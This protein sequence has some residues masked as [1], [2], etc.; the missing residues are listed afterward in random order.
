MAL[1]DFLSDGKPIPAGSAVKSL[2]SQTVLPDWYSNYAMELLSNQQAIANRPYVT[3]PMPRVAGFTPQQQQGFN[4]TG[5]AATAYQPGLQ[6]AN[7]TL[8][9]ALNASALGAAQ[10]YFS[11]AAGM[12]GAGAAQ[13][14][15]SAAGQNATNVSAYMNPYTD[16]V[17][18]RIGDLGA[19]TLQEK[20]LPAITDRYI[21]AGQLQGGLAG[22]PS[23][24][25]TDTAR[26]LRDT[27]EG[28]TAQ[29]AQALQSGYGQ[30]QGAMQTDLARQAGLAGTMGNLVQGDQGALSAIGSAVGGLGGADIS[31]R[32]QGADQQAGL[33]AQAQQ[34]G[35]TGAGALAGVGQQQQSLNQRNLDTAYEDF[36]RQRGYPQEQINSALSTFKGIAQGVP[37]ATQESG[38]VPT[39]QAQQYQ[40]STA[41]QI[42]SVLTGIGGLA[43]MLKGI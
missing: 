5:Q 34:L 42:G 23:G 13:P 8:G 4:M 22:N 25:Q 33:A 6:T 43:S 7:N 1:T 3:A 18:N 39:G 2:T 38:I 16:Q 26:A 27:M 35:L 24:M 9:G 37:T 28:I 14:F 32:M 12:S 11:Q 40:P 20:L 21:S 41:A 29:Q 15:L 19:R 17:V 30:A 10:P 31:R 36:L